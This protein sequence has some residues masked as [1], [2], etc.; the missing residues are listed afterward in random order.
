MYCTSRYTCKFQNRIFEARVSTALRHYIWTPY[1]KNEETANATA[2][3]C[4]HSDM[5]CELI[6]ASM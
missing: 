3:I 6:N 2:K 4:M 5:N 1:G